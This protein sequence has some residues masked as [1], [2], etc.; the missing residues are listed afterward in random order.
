MLLLVT[1]RLM[2]LPGCMFDV[3]TLKPAGGPVTVLPAVVVSDNALDIDA[4]S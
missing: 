2:V 4:A 3:S 1:V